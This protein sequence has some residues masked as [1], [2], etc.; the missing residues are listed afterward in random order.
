MVVSYHTVCNERITTSEVQEH[1]ILRADFLPD[2]PTRPLQHRVVFMDGDYTY[3][4]EYRLSVW[5]GVN[6]IAFGLGRYELA[7][8]RAC[9]AFL[10]HALHALHTFRCE[11]T[12]GRGSY[13]MTAVK[14]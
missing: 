4:A 7:G 12:M 8:S 9:G 5:N 10:L 2:P 1:G 11:A 6:H 3:R 14:T 13:V